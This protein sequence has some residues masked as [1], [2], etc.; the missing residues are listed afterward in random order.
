MSK[1]IILKQD[2]RSIIVVTAIVEIVSRAAWTVGFQ[3]SSW[4]FDLKAKLTLSTS[5]AN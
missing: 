1:F 4:P 3:L 2:V 5:L